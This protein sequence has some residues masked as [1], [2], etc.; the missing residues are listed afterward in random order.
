M[1]R[2]REGKISV[3]SHIP[4]LLVQRGKSQNRFCLATPDQRGA[5]DTWV[6]TRKMGQHHNPTCQRGVQVHLVSVSRTFEKLILGLVCLFEA[7]RPSVKEIIEI[8][9]K[10]TFIS[11]FCWK[12]S[13]LGPSSSL[14]ISPEVVNSSHQPRI[15]KLTFF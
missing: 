15:N 8:S 12:L 6:K 7:H 3:Q 2:K 9:F 1:A 10:L 14:E 4:H 5:S 13:F 11:S